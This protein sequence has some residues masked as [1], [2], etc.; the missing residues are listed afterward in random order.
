MRGTQN[1]W[2]SLDLHTHTHTRA[3]TL[4]QQKFTT[5]KSDLTHKAFEPETA[6]RQA[7]GAEE[8]GAEACTGY[9]QGPATGSRQ[10]NRQERKSVRGRGR[11]AGQ[12][13]RLDKPNLCCS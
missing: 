11:G 12:A 3:P 5:I 4:V 2:Q 1:Q 8:V 13:A 10:G 7:A 9:E 6:M